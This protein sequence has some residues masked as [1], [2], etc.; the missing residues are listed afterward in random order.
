MVHVATCCNVSSRPTGNNNSPITPFAAPIIGHTWSF[1]GTSLLPASA[2]ASALP[3]S[4]DPSALTASTGASALPSVYF[5]VCRAD[6]NPIS[7]SRCPAV[8]VDD[9]DTTNTNR[10]QVVALIPCAFVHMH[11]SAPHVH[12]K[13]QVASACQRA[14]CRCTHCT[15]WPQSRAVTLWISRIH[16]TFFDAPAHAHSRTSAGAAVLCVCMQVD[17]R[18]AVQWMR[19]AC[20]VPRGPENIKKRRPTLPRTYGPA[21]TS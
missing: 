14:V 11:Q 8:D 5:D 2:D 15:E 1:G 4:T 19:T 20:M 12:C 9:M 16:R 21:R 7:R 6:T 18:M 10:T 17:A 13:M 3:A